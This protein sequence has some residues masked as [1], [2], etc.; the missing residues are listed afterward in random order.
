[1]SPSSVYEQARL[2][3]SADNIRLL[4]IS[5]Q[6]DGALHCIFHIV[7]LAIAPPFIALSYEWGSKTESRDIV[8]DGHHVTIRENLYNALGN[9]ARRLW[10]FR[11]LLVGK[12]VETERTLG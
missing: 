7:P 5:P 2:A 9:M 11:K 8:L 1:M 4:E 10:K 12:F 3:P 6:K